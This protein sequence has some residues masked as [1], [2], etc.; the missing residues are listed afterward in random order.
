MENLGSDAQI[1]ILKNL[2][3]QEIINVCQSSQKLERICLDARYDPLWRLKIKEE[4]N[5]KY[6][7]SQGQIMIPALQE[8][9]N[10]KNAFQKYQE[11]TNM[12]Q[13]EFYVLTITD[14]DHPDESDSLIFDSYEKLILN[15]YEQLGR[16]YTFNQLKNALSPIATGIPIKRNFYTINKVKLMKVKFNPEREN[17]YNQETE[18]ESQQRKELFNLSNKKMKEKRFNEEINGIIDDL[19]RGGFV[20]ERFER[21]DEYAREI[22]M[23][24]VEELSEESG[25]SSDKLFVFFVNNLLL[26]NKQRKSILGDKYQGDDV[27]SESD[28]EDKDEENEDEEENEEEENEDDEENE[29]EEE[30]EEDEEN[31]DE[32]DNGDEENE[33]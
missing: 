14:R 11:L 21:D 31:E 23:E 2:K 9:Y 13:Q 19:N 4:F 22:I 27:S 17:K 3:G 25:I 7:P 32:E 30:N 20:P 6:N 33:E 10:G 24:R 29:D 28:K 5:I 16:N 12:Y 15:L 8:Y 26:T 1:N 18:N